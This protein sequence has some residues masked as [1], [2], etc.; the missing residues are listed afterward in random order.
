ML[1]QKKTAIFC[2]QKLANNVGPQK[3]L[4]NQRVFFWKKKKNSTKK[5]ANENREWPTL[6]QAY[7]QRHPSSFSKNDNEIY[8]IFVFL[9]TKKGQLSGSSKNNVIY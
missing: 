4:E 7:P 9:F 6:A 5:T 8:D 3:H 2:Q 1:A